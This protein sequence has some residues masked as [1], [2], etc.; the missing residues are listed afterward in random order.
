MKVKGI[1]WS[2]STALKRVS[3]GSMNCILKLFQGLGIF[4]LTAIEC[5]QP[6]GLLFEHF[7][8]CL[9]MVHT[10]VNCKT[11]RIL[12]KVYSAFVLEKRF[13]GLV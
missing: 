6:N 10:E 7:W 5:P 2:L 1:E 3:V 13:Y 9:T 11:H 8:N 4:T 12:T